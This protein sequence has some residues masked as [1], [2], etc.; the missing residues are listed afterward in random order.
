MRLR[1]ALAG[2]RS[3]AMSDETDGGREAQPI[4]AVEP[5]DTIKK[6]QRRKVRAEEPR[7]V[8]HQRSRRQLANRKSAREVA[9]GSKGKSLE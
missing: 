6:D 5:S 2:Y 3:E 9:A 4:G 8:M 7:I 1:A